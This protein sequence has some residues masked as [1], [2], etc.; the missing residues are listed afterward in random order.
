MV[1]PNLSSAVE[2]TEVPDSG[3]TGFQTLD[4]P[5][6]SLMTTDTLS[7]ALGLL[8]RRANRT[9][10]ILMSPLLTASLS[11]CVSL[12]SL[13]WSSVQGWQYTTQSRLGQSRMPSCTPC[14]PL[15]LPLFHAH[16]AFIPLPSSPRCPRLIFRDI[17]NTSLFSL[18]LALQ[19]V[20]LL[21]LRGT[22][23]FLWPS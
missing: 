17:L 1:D 20:S 22:D 14:R 5:L 4:L 13:T 9:S 3:E 18:L 16:L 23:A 10:F 8:T 21:S 12:N 11:P 6:H 15:R 7:N 19:S 2:G